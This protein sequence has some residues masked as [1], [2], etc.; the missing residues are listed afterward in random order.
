MAG[1]DQAALTSAA[2]VLGSVG[3]DAYRIADGP[4]LVVLRTMAQLASV[5]AD[6]VLKGV[7]KKRRTK[8]RLLF[9][10]TMDNSSDLLSVM[11][12]QILWHIV[13]A[14]R[15]NKFIPCTIFVFPIAVF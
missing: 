15:L 4:G 5:A 12:L 14:K 11:W 13:D 2:G 9:N 1:H 3:I 10:Q 7:I 8:I 6:A